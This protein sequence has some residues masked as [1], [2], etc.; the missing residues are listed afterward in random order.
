MRISSVRNLLC[1]LRGAK[2]LYLG[3]G[4]AVAVVHAAVFPAPSSAAFPPS[5][6]GRTMAASTDHADA[7][8]AALDVMGSGGNAV[9][10][11][12][13]AALALG[14]VNPSASG[15]GGGGFALVY[16]AKDQKVSVFDFRETAP[17]TYSEKVLWPP[18]KPGDPPKD[19]FGWN[20][21]RGGSAGVPGEPAGLEL[22]SKKLGKK[23]LSE[24]AAPAVSLA[25]HGFYLGRHTTEVV[26][27]FKD[28]LK[29]MP[30]MATAFLPGGS[31]APYAT[32]IRRPE[33]A[34]TLARYGAQGKKS[35]YE[36]PTAQKIVDAVKGA[37][38]TMTLEDLAGYQVRERQ[39]LTRTI[40]GRT[41]YTMPAPSAGGLMLLETLSMYGASKSSALVPM[42]FGSS[43][44][45]HTLAEVLRGAFADRA[46]IAGDPDLDPG[47]D[48]AFQAA[49]D[50]AQ[51]AARKARIEP[52]KTHSPVEFKTKEQGTSHLVTAD[53][54]GNVVSLTTT[55]NGPFGAGLVAGDSGIV[56]N[57]EL[58]DFTAADD[59]KVFGAKDGGPNRPRPRAR[60]VSSMTP[61]II[62]E[63]G[64]PILA[65]GGSGGPRIATG[66]TQ[67]TLAR[68]LFDL[69]PMAC[70][71]H[72]RVHT[73]GATLYVDPEIAVDVRDGLR[74]R[75]ETV[76][77][78]PFQ[79]SALQ[80]IAW[81][82]A[83][84]APPKLL[85]ASDPR[86]AG[87]AA[88]R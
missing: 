16:T 57:N 6:E 28:R 65:L 68:L 64:A 13:A 21:P 39:P 25:Q 66:V 14:V 56:I 81:Q 3:L 19:R 9:D 72:P 54:F 77:D 38:G 22:L 37:G 53:P 12:I 17:A 2:L 51:I 59:A 20:G 62:V 30:T 40:D 76:K 24:D 7:T 15:I 18:A 75:G 5:A 58:D 8:R 44:Y 86:K 50:P 33:L 70:I 60:P 29:V 78:E 87:F 52:N 73:S 27:M 88:A 45:L 48:A 10:G 55:V 36:G 71:S 34:A 63:N 69:D 47:V 41:V 61:T 74:A 35:I 1:R 67:A 49:L 4:A 31:P 23:S 80:M 83:P 43:A 46:R 26:A 84:G 11:A 32:R 42:G 82:R 79:G 85:S